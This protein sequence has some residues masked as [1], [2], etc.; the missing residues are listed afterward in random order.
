MAYVSDSSPINFRSSQRTPPE[1]AQRAA[2]PVC[3]DSVT[4][5][6]PGGSRRVREGDASGAH[7]MTS[8]DLAYTI[9][10]GSQLQ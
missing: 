1:A 4:Q 2:P 5:V 7:A 3:L 8:A 6:S 10:I 9:A